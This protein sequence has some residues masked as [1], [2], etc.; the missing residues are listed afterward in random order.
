MKNFLSSFDYQYAR[1]PQDAGEPRSELVGLIL[2]E[3]IDGEHKCPG[4]FQGFVV[5]LLTRNEGKPV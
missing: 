5:Y 2:K 1:L 4:Y 3:R